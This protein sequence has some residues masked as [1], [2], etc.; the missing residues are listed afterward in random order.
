MALETEAAAKAI[1]SEIGAPLGVELAQ[2]AWGIHE[3]INED[4]ARAFRIHAS[5]RGIDYRN[6]SLLVFGGSGPLHGSRV[7][8]K[9]KISRIVCPP[10]AGVMSAFGLLA[11]P[12][13]YETMRSH[14]ARVS[15][16]SSTEFALMLQRLADEAN[17]F[18]SR[19]GVEPSRG[20]LSF[21]LDMRY[22]GQGYG[23]EVPLPPDLP[24]DALLDALPK[25]FARRYRDVFG[26][27]L[28]EREIEIV[29]WKIEALGPSPSVDVRAETR[30]TV[31]RLKG[32]RPAFFPETGGF[33]DC[34]VYDRHGLLPRDAI[35]GPALVEEN[36]S[37]CVLLP[38][39]RLIVDEH[40]NLV[41][42]AAP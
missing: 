37:T 39:D 20:R 40:L 26:T 19:A 42:E 4:V 38:G 9:L 1:S 15:A 2:A 31:P 12:L 41:I 32:R 25:L 23:I 7:A 29:D 33:T 17:G 10:G 13:G 18:L 35:Q 24:A 8:R 27:E 21:K 30:S 16:L 22:E 5:E 11:S 36:E 28:G 3:V 34:P 14:K 6:C